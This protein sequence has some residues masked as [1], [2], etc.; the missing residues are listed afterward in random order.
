MDEIK[1][2]ETKLDSLDIPDEARKLYRQE[3]KKLKQLGPRNQEYHVSMNYLQTLA[4]LPWGVHDPENLDPEV[5]SKVLD[6]DHYGL[7]I[8]KTRII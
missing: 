8:V 6:K 2:L 4:D 3:L 5:C 1:E 7:E